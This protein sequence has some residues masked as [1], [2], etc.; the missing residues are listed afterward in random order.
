MT[1]PLSIDL[2]KRVVDA[3]NGGMSRRAAAERFGVPP[4]VAVKW[5]RLWRET[6]S[7]SPRS[8]GGDQ[9][10]NRVEQLSDVILSMV[11]A[12]PDITLT[13]IV[14]RLERDHGERFARSTVHRFFHRR[15]VTFK[16][17]GTRGRA[18]A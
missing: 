12:T 4:S 15:G 16:K 14:E 18:G 7:V 10:S 3:V 11:D 17:N 5:H 8:Q 6:G 1:K 13:E 9:R 2:R